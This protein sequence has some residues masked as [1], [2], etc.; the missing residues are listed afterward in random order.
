MQVKLNVRTPSL[1]GQDLELECALD[2]SVLTL[3]QEIEVKFETHPKPQDQRLVYAGKM[4]EDDCLL[5]HVLRM[6]DEEL[7]SHTV[8]L[9]CRQTAL[10]KKPE[11][12]TGLRHRQKNAPRETMPHAATSTNL[13]QTGPPSPPLPQSQSY[14][15]LW[16]QAF[17]QQNLD[18][19]L[20]NNGQNAGHDQ[21]RLKCQNVMRHIFISIF[22]F[23]PFIS[24]KPTPNT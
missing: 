17:H 23:R 3:K 2:W 21:V 5:A 1:S 8:H 11:E 12:T 15:D 6:D 14:G 18:S 13:E 20:M 7:K 10:P 19:V 24:N 9:V 4:L 16:A 22:V